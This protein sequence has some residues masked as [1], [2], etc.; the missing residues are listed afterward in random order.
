MSL[1]HDDVFQR[2]SSKLHKQLDEV[3][4]KLEPLEKQ[5]VEYEQM[6]TE[7]EKTKVCVQTPSFFTISRIQNFSNC[8]QDQWNALI[9]FTNFTTY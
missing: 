6:K 7:L 3:L 8:Y 9:V 1:K 4:L 5:T 2:E